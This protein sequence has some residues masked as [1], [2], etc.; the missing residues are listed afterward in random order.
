VVEKYT[1][2]YQFIGPGR[3]TGPK[4]TIA[5]CVKHPVAAVVEAVANVDWKYP[6]GK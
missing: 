2:V 6:P 3:V 5:R 4:S 1:L